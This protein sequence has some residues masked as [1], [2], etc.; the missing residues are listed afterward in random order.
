MSKNCRFI[1]TTQPLLVAHYRPCL[2]SLP[3]VT[4][5]PMFRSFHLRLGV[6]AAACA[7]LFTQLAGAQDDSSHHPRKYKEPPPSA[8]IE[9]TVL[10]A[11]NGKPI[12]NAAVIFH[13]I[14][15]DKDKGSLEVKT[16]EDGKTI[17]DVIPIGDTVR[18]QIIAEGFQTYG[19]D[20]KIDKADMAKEVRLKRPGQQYSIYP[21]GNGSSN[22]GNT[23]SPPQNSAPP[24]QPPAK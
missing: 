7:L 15:G 12:E 10:R 8:R 22:N 9:V 24:A 21:K 14:E 17:I 11:T 5:E 18:M 19:E 6:V 4:I 16:N 1:L 3:G 23:Q 20:Y 13:P 2:H